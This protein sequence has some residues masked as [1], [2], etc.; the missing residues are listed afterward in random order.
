VRRRCHPWRDPC[1]AGRRGRGKGN[2]LDDL[3][4][5]HAKYFE[6]EALIPDHFNRQQRFVVM[7]N[8]LDRATREAIAYWSTHG[9]PV[10]ALNYRVY[11]VGGELLLEI[12]AYGPERDTIDD[13]A[14]QLAVSSTLTVVNTNITYRADAYKAMLR[15]QKA[16]AYYERK[17]GID[18]I[19][20]GSAIALYH[21]GVGVVAIGKTTGEFQRSAVD[22]DPDEEHYV[23]CKFKYVV[24]PV[25]EQQKAVPAWAINQHLKASHRFR[26]TV[27]S[28]PEQAIAF[29]EEQFK[30]NSAGQKYNG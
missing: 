1:R 20:R 15:D 21:T 13:E 30:S 5:A 9:L 14:G 29:I 27:Y 18:G 4:T 19:A 6:K 26:Q 16:S 11:E 8:G 24:D 28:L 22:N 2:N 23:P 25:T 3:R 12:E 7:T 17:H 10:R